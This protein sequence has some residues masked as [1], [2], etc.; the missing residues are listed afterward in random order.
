MTKRDII[1]RK[2]FRIELPKN[3]IGKHDFRE[4]EIVQLLENMVVC[5]EKKTKVKES[6]TYWDLNRYA[7]W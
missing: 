4:Y 7:I 6:F 2:E 3:N 1:Q 5:Q